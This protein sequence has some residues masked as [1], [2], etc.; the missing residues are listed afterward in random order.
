[1]EA[2]PWEWKPPASGYVPHEMLIIQIWCF[3]C[4]QI[5]CFRFYVSSSTNRY[6]ITLVNTDHSSQKYD[7]IS[8]TKTTIQRKGIIM[9]THLA[10][11]G[12]PALTFIK[13][14]Q[15]DPS[16]KDQIKITLLS[17]ISPLQLPNFVLCGRYKPSHMTQNFITVRAQL[18][19]AVHFVID[20]QST[21]QADLVW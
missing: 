13:Q 11:S 12:N 4:W 2:T 3:R 1:M 7:F 14:H 15:L 6:K 9:S 17:T 19:T 16:V 18:W 8:V 20:P 10:H 5:W 21:A